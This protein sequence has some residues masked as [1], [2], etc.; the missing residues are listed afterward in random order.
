MK[1]QRATSNGQPL[2]SYNFTERNYREI[3]QYFLNIY[4]N[5][6]PWTIVPHLEDLSYDQK[7]VVV[8]SG[9]T[10]GID[11]FFGNGVYGKIPDEGA[12]ILVEYIVSDGIGGNLDMDYVN[13]TSDAWRFTS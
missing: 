4:V 11:V 8:R 12:V 3:E 2:Q 1:Y 13:N 9:I 7:G 5:N 6:E 10:S